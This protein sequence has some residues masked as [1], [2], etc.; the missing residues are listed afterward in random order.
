M[1]VAQLIAAKRDGKVLTAEDIDK[2]VTGYA[3]GDV[4][5]YQ[6]AA[7]AMAVYFQS[8][9][10]EETQSLTES[11][12]NSGERMEWTSGKPTVDKHS[13]GGIGDKIS[14][15]L[16]P[17]LACCDVV[18]PMISGRGLGAT[19]GTLDKLESIPGY[20]TDLSPDEFRGVINWNGCSI[21][22][23]TSTLAP[24]DKKF[25]AL[26]DVTATVPSIPLITASILSK[27]VAEGVDALVLDVK[28]GSGAF[29]KTLENA[30][31]LAK[32]LV[33]VGNALGVKTTAV[34]TD[35]NQPLGRMIGNANEIDESVAILNDEGPDDVRQLTVELGARLLVSVGTESDLDSAR[36]RLEDT[37]RTGA[38]LK[39]L[40][41][42]VKNHGG[43]LN[44]PRKMQFP[45][46]IKSMESGFVSRVN[47]E[48]LGLAVIEMG[49]GR[50]KI[51]DPIDHSTGIEWL[52]RI[53]DKIEK[54]QIIA[55]VF[56]DE[57][58]SDYVAN[59]VGASIGISPTEVPAPQL[60]VETFLTS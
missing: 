59:L 60:I 53:G 13:T 49:G 36:G 47:A 23:A 46:A 55:N 41:E 42:M 18:V 32:S 39:R 38:A 2:L 17:M 10:P 7:F 6:M 1:N 20:R 29:M 37:I 43:D 21:A 54:D 35:M 15:P 58:A 40:E 45:R 28:W 11:M 50:K 57:G 52:V 14:I 19:G 31:E 56:C 4:P 30:Q 22:S 33:R 48:R 3:K 24:A 25:Y 9:T 51:G 5:D 16:A 44:A 12:V 8:M 26:R 27:K 34:I